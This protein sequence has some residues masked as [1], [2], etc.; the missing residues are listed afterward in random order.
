MMTITS[1]DTTTQNTKLVAAMVA[2]ACTHSV[3]TFSTRQWIDRNAF[4]PRRHSN[5]V[6]ICNA[7]VLTEMCC[8]SHCSVDY[9]TVTDVHSYINRTSARKEA[10]IVLYA[11]YTP[12]NSWGTK[13]MHAMHTSHAYNHVYTCIH[14]YITCIYLHTPLLVKSTVATLLN[15]GG[16]HRVNPNN[17][18]W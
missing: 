18:T 6:S 8:C 17:S 1:T 11:W 15:T 14:M 13:T 12:C 5:V 9:N 4:C 3:I 2:T 10:H 16:W 7:R